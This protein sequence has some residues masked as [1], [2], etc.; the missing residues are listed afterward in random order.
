[1]LDSAFAQVPT[2]WLL[3][4]DRMWKEAALVGNVS[5][6]A[7]WGSN[8]LNNEWLSDMTIGGRITDEEKLR[9]RQS[10][11]SQN[12]VGG[13]S[14]LNGELYNFSDSIFGAKH[15][16]LMVG[17]ED[18]RHFHMN[19][20]RDMFDLIYFGNY[21]RQ[22]DTMSLGPLNAEYQWYQKIGFGFFDKRTFSSI[23]L[24]IVNGRDMQALD[25]RRV[26]LYTPYA[27]SDDDM[28]LRYQGDF[29][30]ADTSRA[31]NSSK[32]VGVCV[33]ADFN[34]PLKND[35]G[36]ISVSLRDVGWVKWNEQTEYFR[37]DT[38]FTWSGVSINDLAGIDSLNFGIPNWQDTLGIQSSSG[39]GQWRALPSTIMIRTL[40]KNNE[41]SSIEATVLLQPNLSSIPF[42]SLGWNQFVASNMMLSERITY[43]GYRGFGVG[44]ELQWLIAESTFLR[45]GSNHLFGFRNRATGADVFI[46]LSAQL[47]SKKRTRP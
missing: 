32:G 7:N 39:E 14:G 21:N 36:F 5:G 29:W 18:K 1:M 23:K 41:R 27:N 35:R 12:R 9:M 17:V 22:G 8:A 2:W 25:L 26:S 34:I 24:S 28:S 45:I 13:M 6:Q 4:G 38:T 20:S 33:D 16:G 44:A 43:G 3:R 19:F 40:R 30:R 31:G 46:G 47:T 10:M 15:I 37:F 42:V 11:I